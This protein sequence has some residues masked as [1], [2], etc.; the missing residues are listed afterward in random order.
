MSFFVTKATQERRE[1]KEARLV[2]IEGR[3]E[4]LETHTLNASKNSFE[5]EY[6][7]KE[8]FETR[9][10]DVSGILREQ[11]CQ[12]KNASG[13]VEALEKKVEELLCVIQGLE[14]RIGDSRRSSTAPVTPIAFTYSARSV[15]CRSSKEIEPLKLPE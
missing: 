9:M 13:R 4:K 1:G 15:S 3:V 10:T 6:V 7:S 5:N 11:G 14:R 2:A 12:I 8:A